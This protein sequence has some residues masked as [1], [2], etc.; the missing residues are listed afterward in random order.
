MGKLADRAKEYLDQHPRTPGQTQAGEL[1]QGFPLGAAV[2]SLH[3]DGT[4]WS[5]VVLEAVYQTD[6]PPLLGGWWYWIESDQ[7]V[8][9]THESRLSPCKGAT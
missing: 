1:R 4:T 3:N 5:G 7:G 6:T 9:W 2:L 8:S